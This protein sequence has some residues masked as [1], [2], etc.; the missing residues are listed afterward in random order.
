MLPAMGTFRTVAST[1][2]AEI[3]KIKGSRFLGAVWPAA[4]AAQAQ[5]ILAARRAAH[6]DATHNCWAW[7]FGL[8]PEA[9]RSSDDGEPSGTAG[10]PILQEI[11]G[12]RLTD[13]LVVVTRYYGGT[14]L[15]TGGLLRAY[16]EAA[17]AVL[18]AA[19]VVEVAITRR[20]EISFDYDLTGPVMAVLAAFRLA[21][22]P[23]RYDARA[24]LLLEVPEEEEE[25]L[26]RSLRDATTGRILLAPQ[27]R[28]EA[29]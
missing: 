15:G 8:D 13:L 17:A 2:E 12:R 21:P 16:S 24:S 1:A 19:R 10:R 23:A 26:R 20:L 3:D 6:R 14:K 27:D 5:E 25:A 7:R 29:R 11:D 9:R 22:G 18:D 28:P 4:D